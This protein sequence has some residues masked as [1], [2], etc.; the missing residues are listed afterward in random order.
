VN[1]PTAVNVDVPAM[2]AVNVASL[3]IDPDV[4][5]AVEHPDFRT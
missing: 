5:M 3:D 1:F 2:R 4:P